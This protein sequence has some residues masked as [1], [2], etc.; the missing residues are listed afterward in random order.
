MQGLALQEQP[1]PHTVR[2]YRGM[3]DKSAGLRLLK[4]IHSQERIS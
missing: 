3:Y 4:F 2:I 1:I